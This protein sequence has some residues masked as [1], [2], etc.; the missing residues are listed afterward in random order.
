MKFT[1]R[2]CKCGSWCLLW[3]RLLNLTKLKTSDSE[4]DVY[5][6]EYTSICLWRINKLIAKVPVTFAS[7][8]LGL[9][10]FTKQ[11][12]VLPEDFVK[13]RSREIGCYHDRI[14]LWW[15]HQMETFSALLALC[16]GNSS[17]TGEFPAQRPVTRSFD[18]FFDMCLNKWLDKQSWGWWCET[19]SCSL[20]L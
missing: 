16:A 12:D 14:A 11:T 10:S 2:Y 18:V 5:P 15:R 13:S 19:P 20:W 17:V 8:L 1:P 3:I 9:Y 7:R 6:C 4:Y